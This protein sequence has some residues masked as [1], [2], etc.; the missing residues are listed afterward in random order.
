MAQSTDGTARRRGP[1]RPFVTGDQRINR[2]G[3][4]PHIL[5]AALQRQ[6]SDAEAD[7]IMASVIE[8]AKLGD[9]QAVAMLWDRLE[10]KAVARNESG[11]PGSFTGL[12]DVPTA[13]LLAFVKKPS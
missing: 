8:K 7:Q 1:G 6:L 10:G 13:E 2:G 9:L 3:R 4:R 12:E 5:T 11:E